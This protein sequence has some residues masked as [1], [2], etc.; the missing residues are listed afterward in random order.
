MLTNKTLQGRNTNL[1]DCAEKVCSFLN[2][3]SLW[4]MHLQMNEFDFFCNLAKTASSLEVIASCTNDLQNLSEDMTRRFKNIIETSPPDW[5]RDMAHFDVLS[6]K[7]I[8]PIIAG[9]LLKLK[10]NKALMVN[11]EKNGLIEWLSVRSFYPLLFEKVVPFLLGFPTTWLVEA[12]F[13]AVND[14]LTKKRHQL[15]IE[16]RGDLRLRLN[17][18][19]AVQL[20]KLIN[21]IRISLVIDNFTVLFILLKKN[22]L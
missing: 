16:K 8:D 11:T 9:E 7:D 19:L 3:L 1:V 15:Q 2:K 13:S 22:I 6:E 10:E 14:L 5:I 18:G 17:Q 4:K 21:I 12:G 20:D